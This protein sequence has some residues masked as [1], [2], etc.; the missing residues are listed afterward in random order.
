MKNESMSSTCISENNGFT[1]PHKIPAVMLVMSGHISLN[2]CVLSLNGVAAHMTE[3][4]PC[5][6]WYERVNVMIS[7]CFFYGDSNKEVITTGILVYEGLDVTIKDSVVMNHLGGGIMIRNNPEY[8][9]K[10]RFT[11]NKVLQCETAGIYIEGDGWHPELEGN[12]VKGCR[13]VGIKI[14]MNVTAD[15]RENQLIEN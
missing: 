15:I 11:N 9:S 12:E 8:D 13:A 5:L 1:S 4:I 7:N 10:F 3:K 6:A 14:G 2:R